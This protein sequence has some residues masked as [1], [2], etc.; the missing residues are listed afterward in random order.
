MT[1]WRKRALI[2]ASMAALLIAIAPVG[3]QGWRELVS[4]KR[5][6]ERQLAIKRIGEQRLAHMMPAPP[7]EPGWSDVKPPDGATLVEREIEAETRRP[8]ARGRRAGGVRRRLSGPR[9]RR[10]DAQ[11][12][13]TGH[14]GAARIANLGRGRRLWEGRLRDARR[15]RRGLHRPGR[16]PR[17]PMG[18]AAGQSQPLGGGT[19]RFRRGPSDLAGRRLGPLPAGGGARRPCAAREGCAGVLRAAAAAVERGQARLRPRARGRRPRQRC[20]HGR[21]GAVARGQFRQLDRRADPARIQS[22]AAARGSQI[23]R[24]PA[25]LCREFRPRAPRRGVGRTRHVW[26]WRRRAWPPRAGR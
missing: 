4:L 24:R 19:R 2:G 16:T 11:S 1:I 15:A 12:A 23:S 14:A 9:D 22:G 6:A 25:A 7:P 13:P 3:R 8:S 17:P 26:R 18:R 21:A 10:A 5:V 20:D